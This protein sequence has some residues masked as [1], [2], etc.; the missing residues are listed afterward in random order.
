MIMAP[1]WVFR[2]IH[3]MQLKQGYKIGFYIDFYRGSQIYEDIY[4]KAEGMGGH[5]FMKFGVVLQP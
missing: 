4:H 5:S 2:F 3:C 1:H